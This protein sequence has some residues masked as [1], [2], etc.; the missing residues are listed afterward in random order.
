MAY[1][2]L[3]PQYHKLR[4][5]KVKRNSKFTKS[6][7]LS[8]EFPKTRETRLS[9]VPWTYNA[10]FKLKSRTLY[11][12]LAMQVAT[13]AKICIRNIFNTS[14]SHETLFSKSSLLPKQVG[15]K[16]HSVCNGTYVYAMQIKDITLLSQK[17]CK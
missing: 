6:C 17:A 7:F 11:A 9:A 8:I 13:L 3:S 1:F 16:F 10:I 2:F 5:A 4:S 15:K 14:F 12:T